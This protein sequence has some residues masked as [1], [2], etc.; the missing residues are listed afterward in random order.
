MSIFGA[1][2]TTAFAPTVKNLKLTTIITAESTACM[3]AFIGVILLLVASSSTLFNAIGSLSAGISGLTSF[4]GVASTAAKGLWAVLSANPVGAAIAIIASLVAIIVTLYNKCEWFREGV[5]NT[6]N[7]IK[8][9]MLGVK[10]I[11]VSLFDFEWELPKIKLPHFSITGE[12]SLDPPSIPKLSVSWYAK[13][14]ILKS[15]TIFG[16]N[17]NNLLGGGEAGH[18]AV[19]PIEL[20][21]QY[22]REENSLN[23]S[24]LVAAIKEAFQELCIMAENKIYIG[25]KLVDSTLTEMVIKKISEK[26]NDNM[27][28]KGIKA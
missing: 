26:M 10:T 3:Q 15:P 27:R 20:L 24:V 13:G 21:K 2:F 19:L 18:E 25:N 16:A 7:G 8:N 23:N 5:N 14:G 11:L 6:F 1:R 22:I 17:G 9:F 12:F 4:V 28:S